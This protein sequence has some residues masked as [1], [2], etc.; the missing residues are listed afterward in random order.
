VMMLIRFDTEQ[1]IPY[2]PTVVNPAHMV[3]NA[4][5]RVHLLVVHEVFEVTV[6][7]GLHCFFCANLRVIGKFARVAAKTHI[8]VMR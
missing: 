3:A 4:V 1:C 6:D 2:F 7:I 5:P 8:V